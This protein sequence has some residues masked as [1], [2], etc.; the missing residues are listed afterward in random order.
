M[1]LDTL[2]GAEIMARC[3]ALALHTEEP[4]RLT[5]TYLTPVQ[6]AAAEQLL[7]WMR[8]AGMSARMD[9]AGNVVGRYEGA[10]PEAK[11]LIT[12][13]HF[14]TVVNAGKY[15][16][17]YGVIAPIACVK[18]LHAQGLRLPHAIEVVGFAEEEG[19]RFKT[20]MMGSKAI[21]GTYDPAVLNLKD[22]GGV[23]VA[24]AMRDYSLDPQAIATAAHDPARVLGFVEIHIEQGP[25]LLNEGLAAGTV[26]SIAGV[27]RFQAVL[28]GQA[29]HAGTTP[30]HLRRDAGAAAAEM[31]LAIERYCAA[32]SARIEG[33]L[34]GTVGQLNVPGGAINVIPGACEFS[35]DLRSGHDGS[36]HAAWKV[37]EPELQA[38]ARRRHVELSI[39]NTLDLAAAPCAAHIMA[40]IDTAITAATGAPAPRLPSGAGHD[41]MAMAALCP[42]GMIFIRCGN[43]G[44][45]HNPLET[46]TE[47]DARIGARVLYDVLRNFRAQ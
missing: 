43:G 15:D 40:Q 29:G 47:A 26:T 18:A 16:G 39:T 6:R 12:G 11:T 19:V 42:Q 20:T 46:I 36:R 23:S 41:A 44:I 32:E 7:D 38:I 31:V 10:Q 35:I 27:Y 9:A 1:N 8:E 4:G 22:R 14:D 24:Q 45:S 33:G 30:M 34:V 21:A 5:R 17:N 37:L 13:S 3:D 25:V 28:T 2:F